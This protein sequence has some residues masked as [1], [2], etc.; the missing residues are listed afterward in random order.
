M[1][2]NAVV[3][4]PRTDLDFVAYARVDAAVATGA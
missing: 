3:L 4:N 2:P 1:V